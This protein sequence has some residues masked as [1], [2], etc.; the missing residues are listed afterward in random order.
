MKYL[1][2]FEEYKNESYLKAYTLKNK[3]LSSEN[4]DKFYA[5]IDSTE[6]TKT[7]I[8]EFLKKNANM[9]I[10]KNSFPKGGSLEGF[11]DMIFEA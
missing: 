10:L 7:D 1:K 9:D 3:Y 5:I 4:L 6:T 8:I 2:L 11:A